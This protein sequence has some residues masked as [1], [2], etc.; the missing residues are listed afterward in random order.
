MV[1]ADWVSKVSGVKTEVASDARRAVEQ[2]DILTLATSASNPVLEGAW[3][4][5]GVHI[6]GIG[7]HA[8]HQRELDSASVQRSKVVCDLV[9]ACQAEA[10]DLMIPV[11][12]DEWNW[13]Q[14]HGDLGQVLRGEIAGRESP[15]EITL[16]KSVGLAI[17]D[18]SVARH[19][20]EQALAQGIGKD[21]RFS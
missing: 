1:F 8:P 10:G 19:V 20:Y 2:A 7:S 9:S 3:L 4:K 5:P 17:Q 6:N 12:N 11:D 21:F 15:Q 13:K 18:M 14:V 16:F